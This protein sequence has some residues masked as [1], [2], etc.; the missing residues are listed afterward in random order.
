[1][2]TKIVDFF[3]DHCVRSNKGDQKSSIRFLLNYLI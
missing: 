3:I 1:M 2:Y